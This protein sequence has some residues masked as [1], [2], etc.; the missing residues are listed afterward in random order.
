MKYICFHEY[1]FSKKSRF[2]FNRYLYNIG[3]G[4]TI[5]I[6]PLSE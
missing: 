1:L 6:E 3:G 5:S 2:T 4:E